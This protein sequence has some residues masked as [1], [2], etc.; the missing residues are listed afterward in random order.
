[1]RSLV[2]VSSIDTVNLMRY[3]KATD[4]EY[5][6]TI[7]LRFNYLLFVV[8]FLFSLTINICFMLLAFSFILQLE[9]I[10]LGELSTSYPSSGSTRCPSLEC[11][12]SLRVLLIALVGPHMTE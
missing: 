10:P 4:P 2:N 1:M 11:V 7:Y 5:F 3:G 6:Q 8:L 9:R 12:L